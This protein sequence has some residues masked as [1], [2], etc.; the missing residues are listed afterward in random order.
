[1]GQKII[2]NSNIFHL[3]LVDDP[4]D[5]KIEPCMIPAPF[6]C[7][8]LPCIL[9][10]PPDQDIKRPKCKRKN[11]EYWVS[12]EEHLDDKE[13]IIVNF[14][15]NADNSFKELTIAGPSGSSETTEL[16]RTRRKYTKEIAWVQCTPGFIKRFVIGGKSL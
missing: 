6:S 10:F 7:L 9:P 13:N 4:C 1:M 12:R 14:Y 2:V 3:K 5:S 16:D 11:L 8:T 15:A